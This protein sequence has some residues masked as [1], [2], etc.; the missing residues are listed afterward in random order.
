MENLQVAIISFMIKFLDRTLFWLKIKPNKVTYI[1]YRENK[2][3]Y[4]MR[5]I[6]ES[7]NKLD[8]KIEEVYLPMKFKNTLLNKIRYFF[9]IVKQIIHVKTSKVVIIDGNN[10]VITNLKKSDTIV[11]Q[12]WHASAA[13]KKFGQDYKRRFPITRCDYMITASS[14]F[15][16]IMS[17]AF[18]IDKERVLPLGYIDSGV[19][20]DKDIVNEY[21]KEMYL[22][23]PK[24]KD[25]KVVLYAPTFRGNA[26]YD[27]KA[28][29]IDL[30]KIAESLGDDYILL[31]KMHPILCENKI[32]EYSNL[33]NMNNVNIYKLFAVTDILISDFSSIIMDF[34]IME[35]KI[36]LYTPDLEEYEHE[37]G[38]YI[39]YK[40][41]A[42]GMLIYDEDELINEIKNENYNLEKIEMIKEV[43]Y[44][45]K[46]NKSSERIAEFILNI[47]YN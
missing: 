31:Y 13:I 32:E 10:V 6:S 35:K 45:Y 9:E 42:P 39:D 16:D 2:L 40:K 43:F 46:D 8:N 29:S 27:K 21:K 33:Y 3:P 23:Y 26:I 24:L 17:S 7:L 22:E 18:N 44:D 37:R 15:I 25:K 47:I 36:L 14:K 28:L 41:F 34:T 30:K 12:I 19:L 5:R 1:S 11:V 38:M 20:F 4:S